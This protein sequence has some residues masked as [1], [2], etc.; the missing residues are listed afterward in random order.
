MFKNYTFGFHIGNL[1]DALFFTPLF[2]GGNPLN[3]SL[4]II[5]VEVARDKAVLFNGLGN[6][7]LSKNPSPLL[8]QNNNVHI[9]QHYLD[10][11][12][13]SDVNYLPL[14][15]VTEEEKE[16]ARDFLKS[17]DNP[18]IYSPNNSCSWDK[19]NLFAQMRTFTDEMNSIIVKELSQKYTILQF[20]VN[21]KFYQN[22]RS[23]IYQYDNVI[24]IENLD[25]RKL[26]ACYSVI[27]KGFCSDTGNPYL[28]LAVGGK[29]I[30]LVPMYNENIYKYWRYVYI[31][32]S[33]WKGEEIRA[34]YFCMTNWKESLKYI[35]FDF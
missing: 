5:D 6:V 19:T 22:M 29:I 27:G 9:S 15:L 23:E 21:N 2:K 1:T 10:F 26:A 14:V 12:E 30:E 25:L 33:L 31:D 17:Y 35:N 3:L 8:P 24:N 16:W 13:R 4:E 11:L 20:G 18:I 28:M 34:K 7:S 32:E